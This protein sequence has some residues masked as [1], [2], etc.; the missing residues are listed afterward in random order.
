MDNSKTQK[1]GCGRTYKGHD[2][3]APMFGYIGREGFILN[4]ELRPGTQHCQKGTPEFIT[5]YLDF[6]ME[7]S[8]LYSNSNFVFN[9]EK[10]S[11]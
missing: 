8:N 9:D 1:D 3:F 2:G 11:E 7:H 5:E 4:A 6:I 10:F